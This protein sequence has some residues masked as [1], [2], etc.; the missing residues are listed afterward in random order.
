[1]IIQDSL[2]VGLFFIDRSAF[3]HLCEQGKKKNRELPWHS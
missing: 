2:L 3:A 1:M